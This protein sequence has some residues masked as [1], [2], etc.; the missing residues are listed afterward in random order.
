V[1]RMRSSR[2]CNKRRAGSSALIDRKTGLDRE[3]NNA[4]AN[5]ESVV[6]VDGSGISA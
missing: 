3:E 6:Q 5:G 1:E 2:E 4:E